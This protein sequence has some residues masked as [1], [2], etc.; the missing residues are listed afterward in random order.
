[1]IVDAIR[2]LAMAGEE[3]STR[4][5]ASDDW[6]GTLYLDCDGEFSFEWTERWFDLDIINP[7]SGIPS[8][9]RER[10]RGTKVDWFFDSNFL[11][12]TAGNI[13]RS[14]HIADLDENDLSKRN[15]RLL[16]FLMPYREYGIA[17]GEPCSRFVAEVGTSL[18][19]IQ[20]SEG[21]S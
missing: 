15:R 16:L 3:V 9:V 1:M 21:L 7:L 13:R 19:P 11:P 5:F 20:H 10:I 6:I 4:V 12:K 8:D 2:F 18:K 17:L 14:L